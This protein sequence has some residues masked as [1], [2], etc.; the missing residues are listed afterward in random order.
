MGPFWPWYQ[1]FV[2]N[3]CSEYWWSPTFFI[4]SIYPEFIFSQYQPLEGCFTWAWY[5]SI[6]IICFACTPILLFL[7]YKKKVIGIIATISI[8]GISVISGLLI[9]YF[10]NLSVGIAE[11]TESDHGNY[12]NL[13]YDKPYTRCHSY[14]F[15]VLIAFILQWRPR[16]RVRFIIRVFCYIVIFPI[17]F[18]LFF[19]TYNAWQSGG[20]SDIEN[21]IFAAFHHPVFSFCFFISVFLFCLGYEGPLNLRTFFSHYYWFPLSRLSYGVYLYTPIIALC[22]CFSSQISLGYSDNLILFQFFVYAILAYIVSLLQY[23][24]FEKPILH[25]FDFFVEMIKIAISKR[26]EN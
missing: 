13:Y 15:G 7:F 9:C 16:L 21:I 24:L 19:I 20:W 10:H 12:F 25:T 23:L 6:E 18:G 3:Q 8:I 26:K 5:I 14:F 2:D 11:Q 22:S 1:E 4:S 17:F